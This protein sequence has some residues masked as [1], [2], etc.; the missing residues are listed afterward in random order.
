M[1]RIARFIKD[2]IAS[3]AFNAL[4]G[5]HAAIANEQ[6]LT[7]TGDIF[8]VLKIEGM[9]YE[10]RDPSYLDA[11]ARQFQAALRPLDDVE[12]RVY[13]YMLKRDGASIPFRVYP[14]KPVLDQ[15]IRSRIQFLN[16][17]AGSLYSM[18]T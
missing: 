4:L 12:Y 16:G 13:Q 9:D 6:F 7:K 15:A 1:I 10:G 3:G 11:V 5:V 17:K 18:D 8:A 2:Y 14:D